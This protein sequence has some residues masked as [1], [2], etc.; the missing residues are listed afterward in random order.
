MWAERRER[1][2]KARLIVP[3]ERMFRD[4]GRWIQDYGRYGTH[5]TLWLD[6]FPDMGIFLYDDLVADAGAFIRAVYRFL[7]VDESFA[8]NLGSR[9]MSGRYEEMDAATRQMLIDFYREEVTEFSRLIGRE[10]PWL[11]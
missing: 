3:F 10:L 9:E 8:C 5:L 4:N 7:G 6:A 1:V 11:D 2:G